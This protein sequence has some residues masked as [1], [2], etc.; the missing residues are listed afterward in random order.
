MQTLLWCLFG[1]CVQSHTSASVHL[2]KI[3][4]TV[5]HTI[6]WKKYNTAGFWF[7]FFFFFGYIKN[8]YLSF[9]NTGNLNQQLGDMFQEE[10]HQL[11][12]SRGHIWETKTTDYMSTFQGHLIQ[13]QIYEFLSK[14]TSENL[15]RVSLAL[16][17]FGAH[18][19]HPFPHCLPEG[20]FFISVYLSTDAVSTL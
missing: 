12:I 19:K 13:W 17:G 16:S 18:T 6:V 5:S 14:W 1:P 4:S 20:V 15:M 3:P 7:L 10:I 8:A 11:R 2:L 9:V